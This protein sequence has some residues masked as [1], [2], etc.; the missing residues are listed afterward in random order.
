M[1]RISY[2]NPLTKKYL[3]PK[4]FSVNAEKTLELP[5]PQVDGTDKMFIR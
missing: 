4:I 2:R 5:I 3:L 1:L